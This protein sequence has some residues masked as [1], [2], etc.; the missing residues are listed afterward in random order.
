MLSLRNP[1]LTCA[2]KNLRE[3]SVKTT[4]FSPAH[5]KKILYK[6]LPTTLKFQR[7]HFGTLLYVASIRNLRIA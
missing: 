5:P 2:E 6:N 7:K 3:A 1:R 4:I